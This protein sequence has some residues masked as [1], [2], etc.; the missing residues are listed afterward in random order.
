MGAILPHAKKAVPFVK[1]LRSYQ[2]PP[3]L[4]DQSP[5]V[6]AVLSNLGSS[7]NDLPKCLFGDCKAVLVFVKADREP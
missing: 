2:G 5:C 4:L 7:E 3:R 1:S 6:L